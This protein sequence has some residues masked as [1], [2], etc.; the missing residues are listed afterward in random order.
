MLSKQ[1][2]DQML[3]ITVLCVQVS[4]FEVHGSSKT[5]F[6]L[7]HTHVLSIKL[8]AMAVQCLQLPPSGGKFDYQLGGAYPPPPGTNILVRDRLAK[9]DPDLYNVC[10]VNGF[11]TQAVDE[12]FWADDS[13]SGL[14]LQKKVIR[15]FVATHLSKLG[16]G[17]QS[18][19]FFFF[20]VNRLSI[21]TSRTSSSWISGGTRSG[22][23]LQPSSTAGL[24]NA[25]ATGFKP[26][27]ST[28]WTLLQDS[29]KSKSTT[30]SS[31]EG[32]NNR[33]EDFF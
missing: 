14:V 9:I 21:Q 8:S 16:P 4:K 31:K 26:S 28:T 13:N 12:K 32:K 1:K 24:R 25:P 2:W 10:Y 15:S 30:P 27:K 6:L 29:R 19:T 20:R 11:Q 23:A 18:S 7:T 17:A 33:L 5:L 22:V 3:V